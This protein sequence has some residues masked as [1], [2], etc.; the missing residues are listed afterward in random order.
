MGRKVLRSNSVLKRQKPQQKSRTNRFLA[1]F[2]GVSIVTFS[3]GL[4]Y[5]WWRS[6]DLNS[7]A[8]SFK[9]STSPAPQRREIPWRIDLKNEGDEAVDHALQAQIIATL[10]KNLGAETPL[11]LEKI[12][13]I[14]QRMG[15][16]A[17]VRLA[18]TAPQT[19]IVQLTPRKAR[20]CM[21][22]DQLR[23]I[24]IDGSVY[25]SP[26]TASLCPG[27]V[28]KGVFEQGHRFRLNGD[29][30]VLLSDDE[31]QIVQQALLLMASLDDNALQ[32]SSVMYAKYRGFIVTL[33]GKPTEIALGIAPF[34]TRLRK[35]SSLLEK[36]TSRGEE[37]L[38]IELDYQGKAFLKLKKI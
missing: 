35:L 1:S 27:P 34:E 24:G 26:S 12:A 16:F 38:R 7:H 18:K 15:S 29:S 28:L 30:T 3:A 21:E 6:K 25:G 2:I 17:S 36:L 8:F 31:T 22:A 20:L 9:T 32:L 4:G 19:L 23:Y 33:V 5:V 14:I 13:E 37:A 11:R 10:Q